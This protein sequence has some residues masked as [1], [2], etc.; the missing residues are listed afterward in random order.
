MSIRSLITSLSPNLDDFL[1]LL[2]NDFPLLSLFKDTEQ[3]N[4]WHAEG[5]VHI[6]TQMV[7]SEMAT[8]LN[9]EASHLSQEDKESLMLSALFHDIAKPLTTYTVFQDGRN[10]VKASKHEEVGMSYLAYRLSQLPITPQQYHD[11]MMLVGYHQV[12]K[13]LVIKDQSRYHYH[14]LARQARLELFYYLE[15]ADMLGRI[16]NDIDDQLLYLEIF[17]DNAIEYGCFENNQGEL[18]IMHPL[19][20]HPYLY[21][22]GFDALLTGEI[23]QPEEALSKFYT[24]VDNHPSITLLCGLSGVGKS[25]YIHNNCGQETVISLDQIR[26]EVSGNIFDRKKESLVVNIAKSRLQDALR[27]KQS[28]VY[29]STALRSD[30]R[31]K[32]LRLA[33]GYHAISKTVLLTDH[34]DVIKRQ[35]KQRNHVLDDTVIDQQLKRFEFPMMSESHQFEWIHCGQKIRG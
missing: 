9:T 16:A 34:V 25:T 15:R 26:M 11:V 13:M 35:N 1:S 10:K 6:H 23:F 12:P 31:K 32:V 3:D 29:D 30:F 21:Q 4:V 18:D 7:M 28:I 17:K 33:H 27:N 2:S 19:I 14:Q 5:D 20:S 8:I 24:Q 22:K